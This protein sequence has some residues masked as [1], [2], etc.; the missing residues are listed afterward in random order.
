MSEHILMWKDGRGS[1]PQ[2]AS[3]LLGW[4][5]YERSCSASSF[6]KRAGD[7]QIGEAAAVSVSFAMERGVNLTIGA[8]RSQ[9]P[10]TKPADELEPIFRQLRPA[11]LVCPERPGEINRWAISNFFN[12]PESLPAAAIQQ[13]VSDTISNMFPRREFTSASDGHGG[14]LIGDPPVVMT[15]PNPIALVPPRLG[16]SIVC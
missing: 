2:G 16:A 8:C 9:R 5:E 14:T 15:Y 12:A 7:W 13:A 1:P 4:V 10:E 11:V 3:G 6:R